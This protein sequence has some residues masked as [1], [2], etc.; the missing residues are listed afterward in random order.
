MIDLENESCIIILLEN[1]E[2][3]HSISTLG[4]RQLGLSNF[5][6]RIFIEF[7]I[8]IKNVIV[9]LHFNASFSLSS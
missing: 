3:Y 5:F 4:V 6:I 2:L 1:S 7:K 8:K 9:S